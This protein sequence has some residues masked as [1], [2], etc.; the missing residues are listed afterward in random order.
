MVFSRSSLPY[1]TP[2]P[3]GSCAQ[4]PVSID[5]WLGSVEVFSIRV[6]AFSVVAPKRLIW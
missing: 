1:T 5:A 4:R 3:P 6:R 2:W